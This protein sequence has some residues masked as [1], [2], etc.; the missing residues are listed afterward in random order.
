MMVQDE[1][2]RLA[3]AL[4]EQG[5][6][7]RV[8]LEKFQRE[9]K[10]TQTEGPA[11]IL[12]EVLGVGDEIVAETISS[13]FHIPFI[14][15]TPEIITVPQAVF[16][17]TVLQKNRILPLISSGVELTVAFVDPPYKALVDSLRLE[18]KLFV[19]PVAVTLSAYNNIVRGEKQGFTEIRA[20]PNKL[21]LDSLDVQRGG[22]ERY[23]ELLRA[24]KLPS[25]DALIEEFI[26]RGV[27]DNV[28]DIH[29]EPADNELRVRF[30][31]DG[32]MERLVS[33]PKEYQESITN[34]IKT[35]AGMNSF[36][37]KKPQDGRFSQ[38]FAN[39]SY[40][41]RV[42]N[43]P[44]IFGER[45]TVRILKKSARVVNI[46]ELGFDPDNLMKLRYLLRRP[47]G[48]VVVAGPAGS[49][50]STTLYASV[51]ELRAGQKNVL[52]VENPVEY[53]LQFASQVQVDAEQKLDF[54]GALRAI[55]RQN[56]D[57]ILVGEIRDAETGNVAAE[58]ALTGNLVLT[59]M[60][61]SDA[62]STIPRLI[63][64]GIPPY[65]LAPT[66]TGVIYQQLVR[67]ICAHCKEEYLPSRRIL[68]A[69]GLEQLDGSLT[70][71]RGKGCE[72]C[73][74]DGYLGRTAIHEVLVIDEEVRDL[75]YQQA[76]PVRLREV[77]KVKGFEAI[78]FDAAKKLAAGIISGE[79]FLRVLG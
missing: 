29:L 36:E 5:Y 21:N 9:L 76:S 18:A 54:A 31:H 8:R 69:L 48:L 22:R 37:R 70:L 1:D 59:T 79:E 72:V 17:D 75:I 24:N 10:E 57:V 63:S 56:P 12:S 43:I 33:L 77:A 41:F 14:E 58:A 66:L 23:Q 6:L 62:L 45:I 27:K 13:V 7:D 20:L 38:M 32:V 28:S 47:R 74:G 34:V 65:S 39:Y 3:K 50:K 16:P 49:G 2:I 78:R 35:R 19:I 64:L 15:L 26:L 25:A 46:H 30:N 67:K 44:T 53:R 40:D 68:A 73:G 60:L 51:N 61:S 4:F 52:T 11:E 71:F 55:L 42:S